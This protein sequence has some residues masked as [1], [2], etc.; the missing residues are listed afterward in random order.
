MSD[1][2]YD[3]CIVGAGLAGCFVAH[4]LAKRGRTF[5]MY[6]IPHKSASAI[7]AGLINPITGKRFGYVADYN[8][9][10][11]NAIELYNQIEG[12]VAT[13]EL[14]RLLTKEDESNFWNKKKHDDFIQT[15]TMPISLESYNWAKYITTPDISLKV[16]SGAQI[17]ISKVLAHFHSL[18]SDKIYHAKFNTVEDVSANKQTNFGAIIYA[19]GWSLQ[20]NPL[21]NYIDTMFAKGQILS[22]EVDVPE[23]VV[24]PL[25]ISGGKYISHQHRNTYRFGANYNWDE[26]NDEV[27]EEATSLLLNE[28]RQILTV[29]VKVI[30]AKAGV[31]PIVRDMQPVM[32][33]HP[34]YENTFILNGLGS[35][36]AL[37]AP[38]ISVMLIDYIE[39]GSEFKKEYNVERFSSRYLQEH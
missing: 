2:V 33:R 25:I 5:V 4:E 32:G 31:R 36:G 11:A 1:S 8:Q 24:L 18:H 17:N 6:D 34:K 27:T 21:W 3:Y 30:D 39:S 26:I 35:K 23:N 20:E 28:V 29:P 7:S 15:H 19:E 12:A 38:N 22:L 9:Y 13:T 16:L 10:F 37:L 14:F